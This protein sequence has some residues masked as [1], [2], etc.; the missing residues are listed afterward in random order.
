MNIVTVTLNPAIDQTVLVNDFTPNAVNRV[1]QMQMD[2]GGKG[3][4]VASFLAEYGLGVTV[5]GSIG[6]GGY[7]HGEL[8]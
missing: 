6:S 4:N 2:P 1:E 3:V 7:G 5:T 8:Q